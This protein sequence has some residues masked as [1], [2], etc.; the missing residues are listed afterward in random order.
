LIQI[1]IRDQCQRYATNART[2][3]LLAGYVVR[4]DGRER[5]HRVEVRGEALMT[6]GVYVTFQYDGDFDRARIENVA[7]NARAMFEGMP[8]LSFKFF[9]FDEKRQ[10]AVN[11]YVWE[12]EDAAER[13]FSEELRERVTGLYGVEPTIDLVQIAQTVDNSKP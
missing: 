10:R 7:A 9:T 3:R 6:A 4:H 11:F 8:E 1:A 2:R 5:K 12:S 13:F